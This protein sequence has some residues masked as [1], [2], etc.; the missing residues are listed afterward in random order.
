MAMSGTRK[1]TGQADRQPA[2]IFE[3]ILKNGRSTRLDKDLEQGEG[4]EINDWEER[5]EWGKK[6]IREGKRERAESGAETEETE[7]GR[8]ITKKTATRQKCTDTDRQR[9]QERGRGKRR[10]Q[11]F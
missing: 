5:A 2:S 1:G 11:L 6:G 8:N 4:M 9:H 3:V 7:R 10:K